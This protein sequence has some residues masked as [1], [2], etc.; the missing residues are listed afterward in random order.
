MCTIMNVIIGKNGKTRSFQKSFNAILNTIS[1][2]F[3]WWKKL[4]KFNK[5]ENSTNMAN[6]P[7]KS[8]LPET[9][10]EMN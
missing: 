1:S 2:V 7:S 10:R 5:E 6:H 9:Q 8:I 3:N 4:I